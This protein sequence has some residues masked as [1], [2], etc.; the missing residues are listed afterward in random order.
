MRNLRK[1]GHPRIHEDAP[2]ERAARLGLVGGLDHLAPE[3]H[4]DQGAKDGEADGVE[5]RGVDG[6]AGQID[7]HVHLHTSMR[8]TL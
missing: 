4:A 5:F 6:E 8:L 1:K 2:G 3:E 7:T